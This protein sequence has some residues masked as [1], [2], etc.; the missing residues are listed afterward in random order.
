[1]KRLLAALVCAVALTVSAPVTLTGCS[2]TSSAQHDSVVAGAER[3]VQ[4]SFEVIDAFLAWEA[5]TPSAPAAAHKAAADL[6]TRA[7][8]AFRAAWD[9]I[10]TYK[11]TR[12]ASDAT[13]MRARL[14][15]A[16]HLAENLPWTR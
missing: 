14:D 5:S 4:A 10:Q 2:A 8:D 15:L 9:A 3:S 1:M 6:R 7:P 12:T 11:T 16:T 13:K